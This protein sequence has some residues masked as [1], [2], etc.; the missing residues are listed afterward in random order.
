VMVVAV[1]AI[2]FLVGARQLPRREV[3]AAG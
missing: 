3:I 2:R 1:L